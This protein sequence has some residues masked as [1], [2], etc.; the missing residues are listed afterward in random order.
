MGDAERPVRVRRSLT[1]P[2]ARKTRA[3]PLV[4]PGGRSFL[5]SETVSG[6]DVERA[7][8]PQMRGRTPRRWRRRSRRIAASRFRFRCALGFS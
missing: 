5:A 2:V 8:V 6:R 1:R 3:A 4:I 7:A